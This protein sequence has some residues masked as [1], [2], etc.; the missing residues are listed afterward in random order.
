M[1][2]TDTHAVSRHI[3]QGWPGRPALCDSK[4]I[5]WPGQEGTQMERQGG[6]VAGQC[7]GLLVGMSIHS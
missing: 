5:G 7:M 2:W 6:G 3:G 4:H 1:V